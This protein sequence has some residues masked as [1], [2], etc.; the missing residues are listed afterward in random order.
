MV[1]LFRRNSPCHIITTEPVKYSVIKK[2]STLIDLPEKLVEN[3]FFWIILPFRSDN[4]YQTETYNL[5]GIRITGH[6]SCHS[7]PTTVYTFDIRLEGQRYTYGHFLDIVAFKRMASMV[8]DGW[9]PQAHLDYLDAVIRKRSYSL[10]KYDAGCATSASLP[11]T[12]HGQWQDLKKA[13]TERSFRVFTHVTKSL[14]NK[15]FEKEGRFVSV[16][17][18]DRAIR[19]P[20]GELINFGV[21]LHEVVPFFFQAY[22]LI[23]DYFKSLIGEQTEEKIEATM[24]H[25]AFVFANTPTQTSP[26]IGTFMIEQGAASDSV[27]I[28]VR[29]RAEFMTFDDQGDLVSR[30]SVGDGEVMGDIGVLAQ[31]PRMASVKTL[32]RLRYLRIPASLFIEA[33]NSLNINYEGNFREMFERRLLFQSASAISQDVST[34]V[35]NRI[36]KNSSRYSVTK[37]EVIITKGERDQRL[38]IVS[39]PVQIDVG[40]DAMRL[41]GPDVVGECEFF[42]HNISQNDTRLHSV[43]AQD[44]VNVLEVNSSQIGSVP[45]IVDNIRRVIRSRRKTIYQSLPQI[46]QTL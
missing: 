10:I 41:R 37:G 44:T 34:I 25:Y 32:N 27:Y 26:N 15:E 24:R 38:L 2:I 19:L 21:G 17:D 3:G 11:F 28:I 46:D 6:L 22:N 4:P 23:I 16:G 12:V 8:K 14:L 20:N 40:I 45:V 36:A 35:L 13:K 30:S 42:F 7:V 43:T 29:G 31:R 33:M 9:M 5:E 39:G 18:L 1:E